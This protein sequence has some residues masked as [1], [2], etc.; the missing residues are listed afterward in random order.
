VSEHGYYK[1][2]NICECKLNT[3]FNPLGAGLLFLLKKNLQGINTPAYLVSPSVM[4]TK[5]FDNMTP[6]TS[7][8]AEFNASHEPAH[9]GLLFLP[10]KT[11]LV[12]T[13]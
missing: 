7:V 5:E 13:L 9:E 6:G 10:Q 8:N 1:C 12:P 2:Q 4:K 3:F 11:C